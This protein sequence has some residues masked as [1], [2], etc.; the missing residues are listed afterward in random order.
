MQVCPR[1]QRALGARAGHGG[2]A[3]RGCEAAEIYR[4]RHPAAPLLPPPCDFVRDLRANRPFAV[5]RTL[6]LSAIPERYEEVS[7]AVQQGWAL[8]DVLNEAP[9]GSFAAN[10]MLRK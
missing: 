1:W 2:R 7:R 10:V 3:G 5:F 8:G 9:M 6:A 4:S